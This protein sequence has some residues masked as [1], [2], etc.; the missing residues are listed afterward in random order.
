M[1]PECLVCRA[2][3]GAERISPG[4]P[5]H[6]GEFWVVEHAYPSALLGWLV[7]VL[8]RHAEALHDLTREEGEE[9]GLFQWAVAGALGSETHCVKEYSVLFAETPGF[10][11][12]HFHLVPR[13]AALSPEKRGGR[14]FSFLNAPEEDIV[15]AE[16]V[17][18]FCARISLDVKRRLKLGPE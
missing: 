11:H 10:S 8:K 18:E 1:K 9:L 4:P 16:V 15:A 7:I 17:S 5:I 2:N 14:I 13:A 12:V 6:E 3:S